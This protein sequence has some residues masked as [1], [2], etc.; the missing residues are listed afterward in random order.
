MKGTNEYL[1]PMASIGVVVAQ[2]N[3]YNVDKLRETIDQ[4]KEKMV[5]VKDNLLKE[6][7]EGR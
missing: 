3:A 4:Y 1:Q 6:R 5:R 2:E 7:G